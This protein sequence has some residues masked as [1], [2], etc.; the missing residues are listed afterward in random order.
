MTRSIPLTIPALLLLASST[1]GK[2]A[3]DLLSQY[4]DNPGR[5]VSTEI[6]GFVEILAVQYDA[7]PRSDWEQTG[8]VR[9]K[10]IEAIG[11]ELPKE[12]EVEFHKREANAPDAWTWDFAVLK[13]GNRLLGFFE[14]WKTRWAVRQDGKIN[15]IN[16]P[17]NIEPELLKRTQTLFESD[18]LASGGS[19]PAE[20][21]ATPD[22]QAENDA[23]LPANLVREPPWGKPVG[24]LQCRILPEIQTVVVPEGQ[25]PE[26]VE[27]GLIYQ[28]RTV[29]HKPVRYLPWRFPEESRSDRFDQCQYRCTGPDGTPAKYVGKH[30]HADPLRP[31]TFRHISPAGAT[32]YLV[33][34][35]FPLPYDLTEPGRYEL[36]IRSRPEWLKEAIS[37]Y[38]DGNAKRIRENRD[39]VWSGAITSN[40][41]T[42]EVV[43]AYP[44]EPPELD[45]QLSARIRVPA[46]TKVVNGGFDCLLELFNTGN[47]PVGVC[48]NCRT[49]RSTWSGCCQVNLFPDEW[50][51]G[52]FLVETIAEYIAMIPPRQRTILPFRVGRGREDTLKLTASYGFWSKDNARRLNLW[53]GT[54]TAPPLMLKISDQRVSV[55]EPAGTEGEQRAPGEKKAGPPNPPSRTPATQPAKSDYR[56]SED[57]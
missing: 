53:P 47:T 11:G 56:Q 52:V 14:H 18:L 49:A 17:K 2:D 15:V 46:G 12:F 23:S 22:G 48:T 7:K 24:G 54:A 20:S 57:R 33:S 16:N 31:N 35:W 40:R 26:D 43:R 19:D 34:R 6:L 27:I 39:N 41:V 1:V 25:K 55:V 10:T 4:L 3:G 42:I 50:G 44:P 36:Q 45:R 37:L 5:A 32:D 38:Y 51:T 30:A 8:I 28:L 29:S 13:K 9:L 21:P